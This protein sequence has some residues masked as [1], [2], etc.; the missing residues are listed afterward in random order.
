[1]NEDNLLLILTLVG[2]PSGEVCKQFSII[3]D[4]RK[5]MSSFSSK[6]YKIEKPKKV[7]A[8]LFSFLLFAFLFFIIVFAFLFV[9]FC[10][11][12]P[13]S[14]LFLCFLFSFFLFLSFLFSFF[15]LLFYLSMSALLFFWCLKFIFRCKKQKY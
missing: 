7:V 2:R 10:F 8:F 15:F 12:F 13:F 3:A 6:G 9:H 1:M 14:L 11:A 4:K 5:R